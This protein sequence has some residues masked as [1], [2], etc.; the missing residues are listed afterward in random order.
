MLK[1]NN[2]VQILQVLESDL[3]KTKHLPMALPL[4]MFL[5]LHFIVLLKLSLFY[6]L[7]TVGEL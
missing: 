5:F 6:I 1:L 2:S 3:N 7:S 4:F